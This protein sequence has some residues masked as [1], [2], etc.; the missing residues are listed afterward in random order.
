MIPLAIVL[1]IVGFAFLWTAIKGDGR[2][3]RNPLNLVGDALSGK[4]KAA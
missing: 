3:G 4:K 1:A 2:G